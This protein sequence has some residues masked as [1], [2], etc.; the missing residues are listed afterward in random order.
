MEPAGYLDVLRD[1]SLVMLESA[2]TSLDRPVPSCPGWTAADLVRHIGTTWGWA[3]SIVRKGT[4]GDLPSPSEG[5]GGAELVA[6]AADRAGQLVD[7]LKDAD[8]DSDCWTFGLPRSRLF[9][10]RRQALETA[11]HAWDAQQASGHPDP[12]DPDLA[13]DGIDEFLAILL[14]RHLER[15][16]EGWTGQ[17][18]HLHRTDGEGEWMVRLGP[19]TALSAEHA[20][21]QGDVD[22]RGPASS[23][24]LWCLNRVPSTDF[25]LFGDAAVAERWTA[26]ITF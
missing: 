24:Y 8:P 19:G 15:H 21:A 6:W 3:A 25:E 9:W 14:P 17:S 16:P 1:R 18:L 22:L 10:F 26:E 13:G 20:H 5:L 7:A 12:L 11:V 23:L 2:R 4:R